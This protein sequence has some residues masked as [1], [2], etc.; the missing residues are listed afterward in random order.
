M[1]AAAWP[2]SVAACTLQSSVTCFWASSLWPGS[3]LEPQWPSFRGVSSWWTPCEQAWPP[4]LTGESSSQTGQTCKIPTPH[5]R[6]G[7]IASQMC[8]G[9]FLFM[10]GLVGFCLTFNLL[11]SGF[12]I[13]ESVLFQL[14]VVSAGKSGFPSSAQ[15]SQLGFWNAAQRHLPPIPAWKTEAAAPEQGRRASGQSQVLSRCPLTVV[16]HSAMHRAGTTPCSHP[17]AM[18]GSS[19]CPPRSPSVWVVTHHCPGSPQ[20]PVPCERAWPRRQLTLL[21]RKQVLDHCVS[22]YKWFFMGILW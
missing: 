13:F 15:L 8:V 12:S 11:F 5:W 3:R 1:G 22:A 9:L 16:G 4:D 17:M 20:V 19:H 6:T 7:F 2:G 14:Q 10:F 18:Q 21:P